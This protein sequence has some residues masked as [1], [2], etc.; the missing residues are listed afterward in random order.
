ME[1]KRLLETLPPESRKADK[2]N[3]QE[4]CAKQFK[5]RKSLV[6][7]RQPEPSYANKSFEPEEEAT[8][9]GKQRTE[10]SSSSGVEGI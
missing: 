10:G 1:L 5:K 2:S 4:S 8:S 3:S 6:Q 7:F 9:K